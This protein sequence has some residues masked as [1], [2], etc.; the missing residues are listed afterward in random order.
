MAVGRRC[1]QDKT[2]QD[3]FIVYTGFCVLYQTGVKTKSSPEM[4]ISPHAHPTSTTQTD[5]RL[6]YV[7]NIIY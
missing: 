3:M 4:V 2:L 6:N 5:L 1:V 7:G